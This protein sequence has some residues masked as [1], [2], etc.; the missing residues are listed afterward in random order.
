MPELI[1]IELRNLPFFAFHG[2]YPEEQK[3]GNDF[4][5]NL[6]VTYIPDNGTITDIHE[7][8]NYAK[9]YSIL[10]VEMKTPR[11]LLET[12]AMEVAKKIHLEFPY[13]KKISLTIKKQN[14]PIVQFGGSVGV[15]YI[16]EF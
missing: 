5:V 2:L 7:T 15:T 16:K 13:V 4:D 12:F 11:P 9:L 8:V 14:P 3:I 10:Q 1:T 6:F